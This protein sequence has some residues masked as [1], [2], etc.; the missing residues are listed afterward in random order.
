MLKDGS[1][2]SYEEAITKAR[3]NGAFEK[4]PAPVLQAMQSERVDGHWLS[5]SSAGGCQRQRVL[6]AITP[7]YQDLE[8]AWTSFTGNAYHAEIGIDFDSPIYW[9]RSEVPLEM[10]L[11]FQ[12]RDGR[13]HSMK[14]Q[15]TADFWDHEYNNLYDWKTVGDFVYY[16]SDLGQ[17]VNRQMPSY[18]HALQINLYGMMIRWTGIEV[19][20]LFIWYVKSE[21]KKN[22]TRRLVSVE[23][24]DLETLYHEAC[25]LAEPLAWY[26][27]TKELPQEKYDPKWTPCKFCPL[28]DTCI[29]LAEHNK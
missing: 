6:K 9:G 26:E 19:N 5:P 17:K 18:D 25:E 27:V 7:Y 10:D 11:H 3:Q 12:L 16:D 29:G 28:V 22:V 24:M 23:Q 2:I 1:K 4:F 21:G 14:M 8:G 13:E 15:G 20:N